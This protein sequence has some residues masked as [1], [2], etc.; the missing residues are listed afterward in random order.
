MVVDRATTC[1]PPTVWPQSQV[2]KLE[3][4]FEPLGR[5]R[6]LSPLRSDSQK[7]WPTVSEDP[8]R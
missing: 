6:H 4:D 2:P 3:Q 8:L 7:I 5:G 1:D